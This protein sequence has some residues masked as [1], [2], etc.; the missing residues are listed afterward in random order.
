MKGEICSESNEEDVHH[1]TPTRLYPRHPPYHKV[2]RRRELLLLDGWD[3]NRR[4]IG[5]VD[6]DRFIVIE[7]ADLSV[8]YLRGGCRRDG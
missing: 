2:L 8:G 3:G 6:G 4:L 5:L 7:R 1:P